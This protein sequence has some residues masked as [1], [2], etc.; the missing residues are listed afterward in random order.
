MIGRSACEGRGTV[1]TPR[2]NL[3]SSCRDL[4][5]PSPDSAH[6]MEYTRDF[7]TYRSNWSC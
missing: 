3:P 6:R 7:G 5:F 4:S 2:M 1:V